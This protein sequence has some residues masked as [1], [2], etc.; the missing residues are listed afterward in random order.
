MLRWRIYYDDGGTF[1]SGQGSPSDAPPF[2]VVAIVQPEPTIRRVIATGFDWYY[3]VDAEQ[4]WWGGDLSGVL[5]RMLH[6]KPV[7]HLLM[8]RSI[9][10]KSYQE[11]MRRADEDPDF[12]G[13]LKGHPA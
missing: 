3:W 9:D 6:R 5:D 4:Q 11:I 8:G 7:E 1:D 2:G 12:V 10:H 13:Y